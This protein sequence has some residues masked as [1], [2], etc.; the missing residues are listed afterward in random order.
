[1]GRFSSNNLD[2]TRISQS[3]E[4]CL[5]SWSLHC[6]GE[7]GPT[8]LVLVVSILVFDY[9][10]VPLTSS[11]DFHTRDGL[12]QMFPF[13]LS[14]A[15]IA[16]IM[17]QRKNG[18]RGALESEQE[19]DSYADKLE[20]GNRLLNEVIVEANWKLD[21]SLHTTSQH[22]QA[23]THQIP[24]L[25]RQAPNGDDIQQVLEQFDVQTSRLQALNAALL[26][27]TKDRASEIGTLSIPYDL[28]AACRALSSDLSLCEGGTVEI[29]T[30]SHPI[31]VHVDRE[32]LRQVMVHVV[33]HVL[34]HSSPDGI[35]QVGVSQGE[36]HVHIHVREAEGKQAQLRKQ[37][38]PGS[39]RSY[40]HVESTDDSDLWYVISQTIIEWYN[41][42]IWHIISSDGEGCSCSI[43]LPAC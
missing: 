6:S 41:G 24:V 35:V 42:R 8:L 21:A 29:V 18:T 32:D 31:M 19:K 13:V 2:C 23:L 10:D 25:R 36:E 38:Q 15:L 30:H 11:F 33:R 37:Y 16:C 7:P 1:M 26:S 3:R 9:V 14:G 20:L 17:A 4:C 28:C 27:L 12:L 34:R 22:L 43:E 40:L 5:Q 39:R